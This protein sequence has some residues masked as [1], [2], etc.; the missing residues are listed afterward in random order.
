M[1]HLLLGSNVKHPEFSRKSKCKIN[2]GSA[3]KAG[4]CLFLPVWEQH[5]LTVDFEYSLLAMVLKLHSIK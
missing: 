5:L 1:V 3:S 2:K 4:D